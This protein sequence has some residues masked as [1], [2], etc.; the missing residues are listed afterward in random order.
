[1]SNLKTIVLWAKEELEESYQHTQSQI[2]LDHLIHDITLRHIPI[3]QLKI[4]ELWKERISLA[5]NGPKK[6]L[7]GPQTPITILQQTLYEYI[8]ASLLKVLS[9]D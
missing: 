9:K 7:K 4:L 8:S 6:D 2:Q 1:M 5:K 3:I